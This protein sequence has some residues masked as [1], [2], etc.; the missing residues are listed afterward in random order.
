NEDCPPSVNKIADVILTSIKENC[1]KYNLEE[2]VLYIEPGRSI[3]GTAGFTLY[4]IG[5][6]KVVPQIGK[7]YIAVDGGMA[8]NPRPSMYGAKYTAEIANNKENEPI[9]KVTVAGRF[10]ESGDILIKDI[11]LPR[12]QTGDIL[13][14]YNTGAYGYSM[15]SNYN[16]VLKPA[17]VLVNNSQSDIIVKRETYE[18]LTQNDVIL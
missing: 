5:S 14:V 12:T 2:P 3:V 17:M 4:T 9:E 6:N 15:S 1:A 13:C 8:D 7:K 16:R 18:Q 11:E 10:C